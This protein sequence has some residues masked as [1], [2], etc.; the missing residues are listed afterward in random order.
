MISVVAVIA[1]LFLLT[2]ILLHILDA[3]RDQNDDTSSYS[4][5]EINISN[6]A[7]YLAFDRN[8]YYNEYGDEFVIDPQAPSALGRSAELFHRFFTALINGDGRSYTAC[9]GSDYI[10]K[11]E[12]KGSFAPQRL[13]DI[14]ATLHSRVSDGGNT[15]DTFIVRFKIYKNDGTVYDCGSDRA[16]T[17]VFKISSEDG[18]SVI[19]DVLKYKVG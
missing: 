6:D 3:L 9:F 1:V 4:G 15:V 13:Y 19:T 16:F 7:T 11:N 14:S 18:R 5:E 2:L 8:I 12:V 17:T 10:E